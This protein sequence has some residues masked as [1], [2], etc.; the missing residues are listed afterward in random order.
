MSPLIYTTDGDLAQMVPS[1][2]ISCNS[3]SKESR[4]ELINGGE[5]CVM[6]PLVNRSR[7][8]KKDE[9]FSAEWFATSLVAVAPASHTTDDLRC[10]QELLLQQQHD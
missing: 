3:V 5:R 1:F 10:R 8:R 2:V 9:Q 6:R 4:D 7:W